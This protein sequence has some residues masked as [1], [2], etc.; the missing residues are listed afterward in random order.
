MP[1]H[2]HLAVA[3]DGAGWHPAAWREPAARPSELFS[4]RYWADL[5]RTAERGLLDL[6]TVEDTFGIQTHRLGVPDDRVDQVRG[7]LDA[8]LVASYLAPLTSRIGL[9]PTVTTTHTEP[10]H[11]SK[12]LATLDHTSRG[13][14]GWQARVSG[15]AA[16][17][18]LVGRRTISGYDERI[19]AADE[20]PAELRDL[21]AEAEDVIDVVRRLW[22][23]WEDDAEI[24]DVAT[25]RFIDRSKVHHVNFE[26]RF[27]SVRG[28]SITPRPPQGQPVVSVLAHRREPYEL[29][30]RAAD[31]VF[32]T[33]TAKR[34]AEEVLG[35]VTRAVADVGRTGEPLHVYADVVVALDG[36][37]ESGA[38]RLRRLDDLAGE[39]YTCDTTVFAGSAGE[40]ADLLAS[41]QALGFRGVRLRPAALPDD[42]D[43]IVADLVPELQRRGLHRT[44]YPEASSLRGLLGLPTSV[45]NRYAKAV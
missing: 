4:P 7:R 31:L 23:S 11:V 9:V 17:A 42:L 2:L 12:G 20:L 6:V 34:G 15:S 32:V 35:D 8:L 29:A 5:V 43:R 45:P 16:D 3:L 19:V 24:R 25:R 22:D 27:F 38:D 40:L 33:P 44:S 36:P 41:W 18:A 14:A 21:F 1:E 13:R 30:A 37:G 10:F 26:G 39:P 28:P